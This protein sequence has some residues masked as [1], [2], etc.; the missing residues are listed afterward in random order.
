[1]KTQSHQ[2][3]EGNLEDNHGATQ[4]APAA[5]GV[6]PG[7]GSQAQK[8]QSVPQCD[9]FRADISVAQK[10]DIGNFDTLKVA[11]D[12]IAGIVDKLR[13]MPGVHVT[14]EHALVKRPKTDFPDPAKA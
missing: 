10:I 13:A 1:M 5:G 14:V 12:L 6:D 8:R 7:V 2:R 4:G 3:M 9:V 11:Q